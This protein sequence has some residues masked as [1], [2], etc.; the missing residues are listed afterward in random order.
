MTVMAETP[1]TLG[2]NSVFSGVNK[3]IPLYVP[4]GSLAAYQSAAYWNQ[5]TNIQE[6]CSQSQ[7]ISLSQGWNWVS[8][9]VE[10]TLD[11]LK[12]AIQAALPGTTAT[13]TI[14]SKQ[15]SVKYTRGRWTGQLN[16]FDQTQMYKITVSSPCEITLEGMPVDPTTL[17]VTIVPGA[18]WIGFPLGENKTISSTFAGFA[19]NGDVVKSKTNSVRYFNGQWRGSFDTLETGQ[20]YIYISNSVE[21]RVLTFP[22]SAK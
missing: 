5:F 16:A 14:M 13:A 22:A 17:S 3:N 6:R 20:G 10:I 12:A 8:S 19:V 2:S 21:D 15:A 11:D 7:T 9:N 1:P 18:N 4:C